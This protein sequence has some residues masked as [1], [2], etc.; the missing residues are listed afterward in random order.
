MAYGEIAN[1]KTP[2]IIARCD[3]GTANVFRQ[4]EEFKEGEL[5]AFFNQTVQSPLSEPRT[6]HLPIM[7]GF[8]ITLAI[9]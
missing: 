5:G 2:G 8:V 7:E 9:S 6:K 3:Q 1:S 4:G